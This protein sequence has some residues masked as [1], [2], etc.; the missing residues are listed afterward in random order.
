MAFSPLGIQT[1]IMVFLFMYKVK[2]GTQV[3]EILEW[4]GRRGDE[5][6]LTQL[7]VSQQGHVCHTN[8][9]VHFTPRFKWYHDVFK[10]LRG[11]CINMKG[12][13]SD[14]LTW[15]KREIS[16]KRAF[17]LDSLDHLLLSLW[18][19][20]VCVHKSEMRESSPFLITAWLEQF[21]T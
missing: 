2:E 16:N 18:S 12:Q 19:A 7:L 17:V 9:L 15:G 4:T 14:I 13:I 1:D 20:R 5:F 8:L 11:K 3:L 6:T 21:L 10:E